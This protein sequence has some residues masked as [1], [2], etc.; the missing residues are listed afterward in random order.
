VTSSPDQQ[1]V[2]GDERRVEL[3]P[4]VPDRVRTVLDVGCARGGFAITLRGL[5]GPEARLSGVEAVPAA[6]Q[7]ASRHLDEV[8]GGYFPD[9]LPRDVGRFDLVCFNDVLE[10][11]LDPWS[12]VESASLYLSPGGRIMASIPNVRYGPHLE[13][14][15]RGGWDYE[16]TGIL[17][18]THVR[19][20]TERTVREMFEQAGYVVEVFAG[21][22][23]A[24]AGEWRP[25]RVRGYWKLLPWS[26]RTIGRWL[27]LKRHP[28][29][30]WRQFVVVV[31][32]PTTEGV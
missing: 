2:Y 8:Y 28:D 3:A 32:L 20:F 29:I 12:A 6:A 16:D 11:M 18:R 26:L 24:W 21:I 4:F 13:K 5:L 27:V 19:F 14:L 1:D 31:R 9:D 22:N 10:H 15:W 23:S 30:E 25:T 7:V 17:D